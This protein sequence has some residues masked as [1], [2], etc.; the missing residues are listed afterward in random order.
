MTEKPGATRVEKDSLGEKQVP[1]EAYYGIQTVRALENFPISGIP[2]PRR[3]IQVMGLIKQAAAQVNTELGLLDKELADAIASAAGEVADGRL[4]AEF[5]LDI[6]QTGSGTSTNMNAN[7]VISNRAIEILGG[8]RGAKSP[9]HPNDHVNMCQSSNDVIPTAMHIAAHRAIDE[10]LLP[11]LEALQSALREKAGAFDDIIKVG[12]THLQDATPVRLGQEFAG[13]AAM[14]ERGIARLK[15]AQS[16]LEE[17]ALGGTAVGTG[18]NAH[19]DF[20]TRVIALLSE[21]TGGSFREAGDHFEAQGSKD[22]VV[23][24]SGALKTVA[25]SLAKIANDLRWLGAG[26]RAGLGEI[27]LPAV[28]PGSSIM[29]GKVN[30]VVVEAVCQVSAQVIGNDSTICLGGLGGYFE[31]NLMMPVMAHNLLQSIELLANV[32]EI[33]TTKCVEHIEADEERCRELVERSLMMATALAPKIG[34]DAAAV[35]AKKAY[36]RGRSIREV[37]EEEGVLSPEE[38]DGLLDLRKMTEPGI[39]TVKAK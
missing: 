39:P 35:L 1:A 11:V 13:Y 33:F 24:V 37:A 10:D 23:A 15:Q 38:L 12:R 19:P 25:V 7:E 34:Y 27:K 22:A 21:R 20:A 8:E 2:F 28:Q 3:F 4:N 17:L 29:P 18:I 6:F 14:I 16:G 31:L 32:T 5:P 9:V 30:P 36:E 26:P